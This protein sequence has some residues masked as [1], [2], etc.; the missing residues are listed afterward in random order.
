MIIKYNI[1]RCH[2]GGHPDHLDIWFRE[3]Y[4]CPVSQCNCECDYDNFWDTLTLHESLD[5]KLLGA[6]QVCNSPLFQF[7]L[8]KLVKNHYT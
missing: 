4:R 6:P 7:S 1:K 5:Y 8:E 3:N 2:H